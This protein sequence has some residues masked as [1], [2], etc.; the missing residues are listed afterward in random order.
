MEENSGGG[1]YNKYSFPTQMTF[2]NQSAEREIG[3]HDSPYPKSCYIVDRSI[4]EHRYIFGQLH[5]DKMFMNESEAQKYEENF[6][7]LLTSIEKPDVVIFLK[8]GIENLMERVEKRGRDMESSAKEYL[9]MLQELYDTSFIPKMKSQ[10]PEIK[11][12]QFDTSNLDEEQVFQM[13]IRSLS[14][15]K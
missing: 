7:K 15:K 10:Y 1:P 2:L 9:S 11:L 13:I 3:L 5:I 6:G 8:A 12:L 14:L 4:F